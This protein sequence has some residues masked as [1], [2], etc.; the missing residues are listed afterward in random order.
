MKTRTLLILA[1]AG[2]LSLTACDEAGLTTTTLT[3]GA[4]TTDSPTTADDVANDIATT[5]GEVQAEVTELANE[6]Q[7]SAVAEDL[8]E[9]WDALQAEVLAAVAAIRDDGTIDGSQVQE[10]LD[11]FQSDLDALGDQVEPSLVDAWETL[12]N[13]LESLMS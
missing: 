4:T 8:R 1:I 9:S 5:V 3:D 2:L 6:V 11:S 12:R 7:N 13:R 10:A